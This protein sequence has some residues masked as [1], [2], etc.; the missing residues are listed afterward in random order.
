MAWHI[1]TKCHDDQ[2]GYLSNTKGITSTIWEAVVLVLLMR[3]ILKHAVQ[4]L[5]YPTFLNVDNVP[6]DTY[7]VDEIN[8]CF[9]R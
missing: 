2:A 9:Q 8:H 1:R 5:Q 4:T 6:E 3:G 7:E